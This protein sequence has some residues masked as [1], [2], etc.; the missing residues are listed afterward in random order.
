MKKLNRKIKLVISIAVCLLFIGATYSPLG[1]IE[2]L[3]VRDNYVTFLENG[4]NLMS[5]NSEQPLDLIDLNITYSGDNYTWAEA[6]DP[7]N[8][9]IIDPNVYGWD[10]TLSMYIPITDALVPGYGY[11]IYAYYGCELRGDLGPIVA[12][13]DWAWSSGSGITGDIF[14]TGNVGIGTSGPDA[15]LDV[16]GGA[17]LFKGNTG[18]TPTSGPGTRLMWIP[19]FNAFR[20][21][22]VSGSQWNDVNIGSG[23]VALGLDTIAS[24]SASTALGW[25]TTA[26]G[27]SS[28]A[29]GDNTIAS[30]WVSTAMGYGT[31]ASYDFTTAMGDST[32]ASGEASTAMGYNTQAIGDRSTAMGGD[33]TAS[34]DR[35]TT[36]GSWT[37]ASGEA[38]TAMGENTNAIGDYSTA[39]GYDTTAS[40]DYSTAMGRS[41]ITYGNYSVGIGLGYHP[42]YWNISA[43]N[44]MSIMGGDVGIGTTSPQSELEVAGTIHSTS[45]GIKF[46]DGSLQTTAGVAGIAFETGTVAH[47]GTIPLPSGYTQYQCTWMVSINTLDTF[48]GGLNQRDQRVLCYA[49]ANRVVTCKLQSY[50]GGWIDNV[51]GTANYMIIGIK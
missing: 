24:E 41:I 6:I 17:V 34:G 21:G 27:E 51:V 50:A 20:A 26:S 16:E 39:M 9:P 32:V 5:V 15:K 47:G 37:T 49:D 30:G 44:V 42:P 3:D 11:W 7:A 43:D 13:E 4:W 46:P 40:G 12:D 10:R 23:S 14:H 48:D 38:S 1:E 33:T 31:L 18:G 36:M 22:Y 28:T 35:S 19:T 8:G 29:M 45:G 2:T 25:E